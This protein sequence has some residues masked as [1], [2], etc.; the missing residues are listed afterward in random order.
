MS[1]RNKIAIVTGA[2]RGIGSSIALRLSGLGAKV[3]NFD[4]NPPGGSVSVEN[5]IFYQGNVT[6]GQSVSEWID[7]VLKIDS[8][9][10]I[11]VNNAGIIRDAV[12]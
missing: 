12:I 3:Y 6:E 10:D 11:L 5:S 7:H 4:M 9:V 1:F 8:R 2:S